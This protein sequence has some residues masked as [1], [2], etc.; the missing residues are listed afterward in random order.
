MGLTAPASS[1]NSL[2]GMNG[3]SYQVELRGLEERVDELKDKIRRSHTNLALL[4]D[5]VMSAG[6][7]GSRAEIEYDHEMSGAF[8]LTKLLVVLD[9]AVQANKSD[10]SGTLTEQGKVPVFSGPLPPGDH[11]LSVMVQLQGNGS[12]LL[13]YMKG[14]KFEVRSNHTFTAPEG[15]TISIQI[16]SYEKGDATTPMEDRPAIRYSESVS[17]GIAGTGMGAPAPASGG[18]KPTAP[19]GSASFSVGVGGH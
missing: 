12:G 19:A 7:S 3:P 14:F 2:L 13:V 16:V 8:K 11:N 6:S 10:D 1:T 9:G 5:T 4:S 17:S 15:K 18:S